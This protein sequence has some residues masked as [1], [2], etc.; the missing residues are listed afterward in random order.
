MGDFIF[1]ITVLIFGGLFV[2][3]IFRMIAGVVGAGVSAAKAVGK[4]A[5]GEGSLSENMN[6]EF[7]R[8]SDFS[9]QLSK[10][11][12]DNEMPFERYE[13]L[14]KGLFPNQYKTELNFVTRVI[15]TTDKD[16]PKPI[17]SSV[18][19][20][21]ADNNPFFELKRKGLEVD[22]GYGFIKIKSIKFL[23]NNLL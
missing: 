3:G 23:Y 21:Q 10:K 22:R 7:K 17:I 13:I 4:T 9:I 8:M 6:Q 15:D 16:E 14:G 12:A 19:D 11:S 20:F 2:V 18:E 1:V 5:A